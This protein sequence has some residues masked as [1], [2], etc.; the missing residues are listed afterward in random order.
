VPAVKPFD[1]KGV[2]PAT[3]LALKDDLSIDDAELR[4][5]VADVAST[6]GITAILVNG[7]ASEVFSCTFDEQK[8]ILESSVDEVGD[9]VPVLSG[10]CTDGSLEAAR[11]ARMSQASGARGL[12]V[13]PPTSMLPGGNLRPEM[14]L[15]H[16]RR[17][18]DATDLPLIL[19]QFPLDN[20]MG[21]TFDTL[22]KLVEEVPTIRAI[23][24]LI[25]NPMM[26]ERNIRAL[27][28]M[29]RPVNVLTTHSSWLIGSLAMGAAGILSGS[30]SII[31]DRHVALFD[32]MQAEDL[33][34]AKAV[35]DGIYPLAQCFYAPPYLDNHNRMKEGLKMLGRL[36]N[37]TVR[38][39]LYKLPEHEIAAVRRALIDAKMLG[40]DGRPVRDLAMRATAAE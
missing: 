20:G 40:A 10:V 14:A 34:R 1:P 8:Q 24:D 37:T 16:F 4:R 25:S 17:I 5:H 35:N 21:Y 28:S 2:I 31:A 29:S 36:K 7:H 33:P 12:L 38:P 15:T 6:P 11:I 39:P 32:A 30:G 18:A 22:I 19:V 27:H 26:H 23:K 9:I 3:L 13:F